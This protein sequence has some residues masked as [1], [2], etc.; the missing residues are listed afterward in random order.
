MIPRDTIAFP[1]HGESSPSS[2]DYVGNAEPYINDKKIIPIRDV[3]KFGEEPIAQVA[4]LV[5]AS[6][7]IPTKFILA[8]Y[9]ITDDELLKWYPYLIHLE[10]FDARNL[11]NEQFLLLHN[12]GWLDPD[13]LYP[14]EALALKAV[15]PNKGDRILPMLS[16]ADLN[17][18]DLRVLYVQRE[19]ESPMESQPI[20]ELNY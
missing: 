16:K 17:K 2:P 1:T 19:D 4:A 9:E 7:I 10:N 12:Q 3:E 20:I 14:K 8:P 5:E 18:L 11:E 13:K 6:T 15:R